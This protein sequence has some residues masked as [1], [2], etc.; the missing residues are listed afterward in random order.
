[1]KLFLKNIYEDLNSKE[2]LKS[3]NA[4]VLMKNQP[5]PPKEM[6][7]KKF[8]SDIK[9]KIQTQAENGP[10]FDKTVLNSIKSIPIKMDKKETQWMANIF[11]NKK[12]SKTDFV[13]APTYENIEYVLNF[14][15]N[16]KE[17]ISKFENF[18]DAMKSA[19]EWNDKVGKNQKNKIIQSFDDGYTVVEVKNQDELNY[20]GE[21]MQ[22]CVAQYCVKIQMGN[23]RIFSLRD[24]SGNPHVTIEIDPATKE[25]VQISGKQ[26]RPPVKKYHPYIIDFIK[27]FNIGI[28]K[29]QNLEI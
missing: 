16:S 2:Y 1:M 22:H 6:D 20:E 15:R 19:F 29:Y 12:F 10:I 3:I 28:S 4:S 23:S 14:V 27:K 25:V 5:S 9:E 17:D 26:N 24:P 13:F 8:Y 11:K 21:E 7:L 18:S